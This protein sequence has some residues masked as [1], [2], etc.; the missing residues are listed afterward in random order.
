MLPL[1]QTPMSIITE[2]SSV[3]GRAFV[4]GFGCV[5]WS[6]G[7]MVLPLIGWLLPRWKWLKIVC[8]LPML[9]VFLCWKII[10]ESPRWLVTQ[11]RLKDARE[12]MVKI[13]ETN[14]AEVPEDMN[15]K[16]QNVIDENNET[17]YGYLSLFKNWQLAKR[18]ICVTVA[19]TASAFVY[20]QLVINIGNMAGNTFL[21]MFLLGLVEG[22]GCVGAVFL[23]DKV[24]NLAQTSLSKLSIIAVIFF[25]VWP[26]MDSFWNVIYQC[27]TLFH[28]NVGSL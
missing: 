20:Y 8:T 16:L 1:F 23:A 27:F 3:K 11:G 4:I 19:F 28:S 9:F 2:I 14:K 10:P 18:T 26:Q 24:K 13:A 7:N 21:N 17:A 5:T 6:L 25:T 15:K 12:V 22:P